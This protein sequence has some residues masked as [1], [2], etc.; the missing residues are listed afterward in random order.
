[1]YMKKMLRELKENKVR[2]AIIF[3]ILAVGLMMVIGNV[4]ASSNVA[5]QMDAYFSQYKAESG[6]FTTAAKLTEDEICLLYTSP[7][8]RD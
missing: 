2:Y 5:D 8:P 4:T 6:E 3:L 1:M 7:S